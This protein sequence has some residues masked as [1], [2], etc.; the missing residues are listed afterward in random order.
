MYSFL[1]LDPTVPS[2]Y[3]MQ[4]ANL[5]LVHR[6]EDTRQ[7]LKWSVFGR[8]IPMHSVHFRALLCAVTRDCIEP[9][10]SSLQCRGNAKDGECHRQDQSA[11][12]IL[13]VNLEQRLIYEG[14]FTTGAQG[15]P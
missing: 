7:L 12:N 5:L 4:E 11:L 13:L 3:A 15:I 2:S 9:K 1:P 10:G 8:G 6:S 14:I